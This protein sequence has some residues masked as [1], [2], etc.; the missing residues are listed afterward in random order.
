MLSRTGLSS[1]DGAQGFPANERKES[2]G[3]EKSQ[4]GIEVSLFAESLRRPSFLQ[5]AI[6][7]GKDVRRFPASMHFWRRWHCPMLAGRDEIWLFV[8][9]SQRSFRGNDPSGMVLMALLLKAIIS[10]E[11]HCASSFGKTVNLQSEKKATLSL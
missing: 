6:S 5:C 11:R 2:S 1:K 4:R 7:E 8:R 10:R 9:M 3:R